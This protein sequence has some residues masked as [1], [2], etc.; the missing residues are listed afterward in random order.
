[1]HV[2]RVDERGPASG[3]NKCM[4]ILRDNGIPDNAFVFVQTNG[5]KCIVNEKRGSCSQASVQELYVP[6]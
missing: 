3:L 4:C 5:D 2:D 6:S 1:M